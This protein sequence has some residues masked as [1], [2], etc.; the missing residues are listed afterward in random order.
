MQPVYG[1]DEQPATPGNSIPAGIV[2]LTIIGLKLAVPTE[3]C[4]VTGL[5][6]ITFVGLKE[7]LHCVTSGVGTGVTVAVGVAV[8]SIPQIPLIQAC[9]H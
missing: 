9:K 3:Y 7:T 4:I 6:T 8:G 1:A 2:V 5:P